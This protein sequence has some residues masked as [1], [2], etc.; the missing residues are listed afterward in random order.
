EKGTEDMA[1]NEARIPYIP[2]D[3]RDPSTVRALILA[4]T[5]NPSGT[6]EDVE[7]QVRQCCTFIKEMGWYLIHPDNFYAF[8]E[9]KSGMRQVRRTVLKKVLAMAQREEVDV[10]VCLKLARMD[11]QPPR[12]WAAIQMAK[13]AGADFRFVNHPATRGKLPDGEV[14]DLQRFIED[15]YD[16][17]EAKEIVD[18]LSP[19]KLARYTQGLPHGGRA[20]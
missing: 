18:R 8:A 4:R 2:I 11:R 7:S 1:T 19:G 6:Q 13:D 16:K 12:R 20:G 15:M 3:E 17:R 5:S 9:T 14:A 10:I